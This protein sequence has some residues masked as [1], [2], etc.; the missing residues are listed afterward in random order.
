MFSRARWRLT[1]WYAGAFTAILIVIGVAVLFTTRTA[2]YGQ[3]NDD[4]QVRSD[5]LLRPIGGGQFN[6]GR[7]DVFQFATVGGYFYVITGPQGNVFQASDGIDQIE[8]PSVATLEDETRDGSAFVAA[9]ATDGE[10]LRV[11]VRPVQDVLGRTYYF[12]V[13]RSIEP[14]QDAIRRL[15]FILSAGGLAGLVLAAGTGFWLAGRA[16]RPIQAAM[17]AQRT[18]VADASHELRTPLSLIRAN[19]EMLKR[20]PDDPTDITSVDDIIQ[21][22]DHLTYLVGQ[23]LTLA[24]ADTP[25]TDVDGEPVL[26]GHVAANIARQMQLLAS[27]KAITVSV[28]TAGDTIVGGDEQRLSELL[29]I[30][31]DNAIKYTES[32]GAIQVSVKG[33]SGKVILAVSDTGQGIPPDALAHV[34]DRFY[35]VDKARS[36]EMGGTGLG[37]AIARWIAESHSGKISAESE[38][39]RGTTV[40]VELPAITALPAWSES[41]EPVDSGESDAGAV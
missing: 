34:F 39:G 9:S 14:E 18:F 8:L 16:L 11:Y 30:L 33:G 21:E 40:T 4:L 41:E 5:R 37:L 19:A 20:R 2:L 28:D 27:E 31:L 7:T 29:I 12:Q 3:V 25:R 35:R 15:L 22:T 1:L 10:D 32:G 17:D 36:R 6:P 23:M 38:V 24:R 26:L 13:G